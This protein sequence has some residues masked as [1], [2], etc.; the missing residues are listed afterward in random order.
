MP[1]TNALY[2]SLVNVSGL[3]G[4]AFGYLPPHGRSLDNGH[5]F[6]VFGDIRDLLATNRRKREA[7]E[8]DL[9]NGVI[10][11]KYTPA[12][13]VYD[14]VIKSAQQLV[15]YNG[16]AGWVDPSWGLF[17]SNAA[18]DIVVDD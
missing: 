4:R 16:V 14:P 10:A 9:D 6:T 15:V 2:T 8:R 3:D 11:I 7:L 1:T 17:S 13:I 12:P 18:G 5:Q